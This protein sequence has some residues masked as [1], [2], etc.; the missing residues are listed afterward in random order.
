[1]ERQIPCCRVDFE[2]G[3]GATLRIVVIVHHTRRIQIMVVWV[4]GQ[5]RRLLY[6]CDAPGGP[7]ISGCRIKFSQENPVATVLRASANVDAIICHRLPR[8]RRLRL[9]SRDNCPRNRR[10]HSEAS[11]CG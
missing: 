10:E 8:W 6:I 4:E 5:K 9:C 11:S 7:K 3:Y 2:R 1:E